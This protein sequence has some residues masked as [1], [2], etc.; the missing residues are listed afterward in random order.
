MGRSSPV[1]VSTRKWFSLVTALVA[2]LASSFVAPAAAGSSSLSKFKGVNTVAEGFE[3][4]FPYGSAEMNAALDAAAATGV[5]WIQLSFVWYVASINSTAGPYEVV[6]S[7]SC[8]SG[9]PFHN[10]SSP[11]TP[12][13]V[14][15]IQYAHSK[16]LKVSLRPMIDPDWNQPA[17]NPNDCYRGDI[18]NGFSS[19]EWTEWFENYNTWLLTW[20][21]VA[22]TNAVEAFCVGAELTATES[23]QAE[24]KNTVAAVRSAYSVENGIVYYSATAAGSK[25]PWEVSDVIGID[26]YPNLGLTGDPT[27]AT[28]EE[29][30]AG[31]QFTIKTL[32][33]L[34]A[35]NNGKAVM[36]AES[37]ICSV[38][39]TGLYTNPAFWACYTYPVS[40]DVQAKYYQSL[41]EAAWQEEW[42]GG[43][44]FWK[45][46]WQGGQGDQ[47]FFPLN[48]TAQNVMKEYFAGR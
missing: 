4:P 46:A 16:G 36:F 34:S 25:F 31:W 13:V 22:N 33:Q 38:N 3:G 15:T 23:Q 10:A 14:S 27:Q 35:S 11:S 40:E 26:V 42:M 2:S 41:F 19:A 32:G 45:W 21:D 43:V 29:L 12:A 6:K 17:N 1:V 28:V 9:A 44:F 24:W 30:V 39:K 7:P 48:K 5:E 47:T 37:G 18:G 20:V 8:P